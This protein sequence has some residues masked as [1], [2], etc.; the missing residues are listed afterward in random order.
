MYGIHYTMGAPHISGYID[1]D[2][3]SDVDDQ[4]STSSF[5]FCLGSS[6]ITWLCKRQHARALSSIEAKYQAALLAS[7][8]AL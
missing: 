2:W 3:A 1:S 5:M 4:K 7:Q 8:E 6:H